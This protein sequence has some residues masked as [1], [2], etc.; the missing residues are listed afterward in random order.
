MEAVT[1]SPRRRPTIY[2]L[3]LAAVAVVALATGAAL[4]ARGRKATTIKVLAQSN[5]QGNPQLQA[6][7]DR[8]Q[9]LNPDIKIDATYLPIGTT[10]ANTLRTQLQGGNGPDVFYVTAGSGGLQS[11]L[12]LAKAGYVADLV[13]A[14]WVKTLPLAPANKPLLLA[15][16]QADRAAVR[17]G[18]GRRHVPPRRSWPTSGSR[19]RRR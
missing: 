9:Q 15:P 14:P 5:G 17:R 16:R 8:F 18:A 19:C 13:E 4:R 3:A 11:V 12:P 10:Y 2:G 6:I 1:R 7:F